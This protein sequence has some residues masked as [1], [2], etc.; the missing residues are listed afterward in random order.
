MRKQFP[1]LYTTPLPSNPLPD[2]LVVTP[3]KAEDT[4]ALGAARAARTLRASSRS[5]A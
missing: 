3:I 2:S 4:P 5:T 1:Q